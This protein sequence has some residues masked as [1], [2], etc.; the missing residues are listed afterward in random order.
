MSTEAAIKI[1]DP[2]TA[3]LG[4]SGGRSSIHRDDIAA[5]LA[6]VERVTA[7]KQVSANKSQAS[8]DGLKYSDGLTMAQTGQIMQ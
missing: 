6:S 1:F 5:M 4:V 8:A 3:K 7:N 2:C